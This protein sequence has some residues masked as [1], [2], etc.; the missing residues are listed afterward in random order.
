MTYATA[1]SS[2][3]DEPVAPPKPVLKKQVVKKGVSAV[4]KR[5]RE[6]GPASGFGRFHECRSR[7]VGPQRCS[8]VKNF[9]LL[10]PF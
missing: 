2:T 6:V 3:I 5:K 8:A 10:I 7:S 9:G 1:Y 4:V